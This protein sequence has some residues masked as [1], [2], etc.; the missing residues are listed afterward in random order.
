MTDPFGAR[1]TLAVDG[2]SYRIARLD[3]LERAGLSL[4]RLPFSLR[5][6]LENLLRRV[7]G[8]VVTAE[9][10]EAVARWNPAA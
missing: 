3:A 5:V 2:R 7:D 4:Q 9:D 10:V 6:L 1:S 8:K